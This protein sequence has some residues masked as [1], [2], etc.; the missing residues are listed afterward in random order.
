MSGRLTI[1]LGTE[2]VRV[3][4]R[5]G[6]RAVWEAMVPFRGLV[7]LE[8]QLRQLPELAQG[9]SLPK[10]MVVRLAVP[11]VQRRTLADLPPVPARE[12][13]ALL[14]HNAARFFRQNGHPLVTDGAWQGPRGGLVRAAAVEDAVA[15]R[16]LEAARTAGFALED[17]QPSDGDG[18]PL[19]LL[20]RAEQERRHRAAWRRTGTLAMVAVA[21]WALCLGAAALGLWLEHRSLRRELAV[22][23][24]PR[25]AAL[26]LRR[27]IRDA[28]AEIAA[29][30][31][32]RKARGVLAFRVADIVGALP[33]GGLQRMVV[34]VDGSGE[35][36]GTTPSVAELLADLGQVPGLRPRLAS[37]AAREAGRDGDV[38]RYVIRLGREGGP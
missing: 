26:H 34:D 10:R 11:L 15:A 1:E 32:A 3:E 2:Q 5:R 28:E 35:L 30:T 16:V 20:P 6:A 7:H 25:E 29:L 9:R 21:A 23:A 19:S 14:A 8:D 38:E 18:P 22:L 24:E 33:A 4:V 17:I 37:P 36:A 12:L 13:R 31:S 27:E